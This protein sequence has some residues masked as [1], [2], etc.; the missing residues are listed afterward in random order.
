MLLICTQCFT[1]Y[2]RLM[3][4]SISPKGRVGEED[5]EDGVSDSV[6]ELMSSYVTHPYSMFHQLSWLNDSFNL[7]KGEGGGG[8]P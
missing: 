5:P 8:G 3:T 2:P 4:R 1:N 7:T 6:S